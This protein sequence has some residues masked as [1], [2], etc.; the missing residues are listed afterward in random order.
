MA[1]TLCPI[2][3]GR[4]DEL[5]RLTRLVEEAVEGRGCLT[6]LMGEAGVGKSRLIRAVEA[7]AK[8][9]GMA[10]LVGR[11]VPGALSLPFRPLIE[12][13]LPTSRSLVG[14]DI[15]EL[16][17]FLGHLG[18][19]LPDLVE[20]G[21]RPEPT[22]APSELL[23]GEEVVR[24]LRL[25]GARTGC[26]LVLEDLHWADPETFAV[27]EYLAGV[28][29]DERILIVIS[30]RPERGSSVSTLV[31][32]LRG[33]EDGVL[34]L[35]PFPESLGRQVVAAC[36]ATTDP[37]PLLTPLVLSHSDGLP[38]LME[39]LLAGLVA[40]GSLTR[41]EDGSWNFNPP[42]RVPVPGSLADSVYLRLR[43]L[44]PASQRVI[45]AASLLGRRF[46]WQILPGIAGLDG[47][48]VVEALRQAVD[49]Q[50]LAVDRDSFRFRHALTRDAVLDQIL[51]P[52]RAELA[53]RTLTA[54]ERAHPGLPDPWCD[55]AAD[56]A[57]AQG[58]LPKA[59][60]LVTECA[61]RALLGGALASAEALAKRATE[62]APAHSGQ[63]DDAEEILVSALALAG[64]VSQALHRGKPLLDRLEV[65]A[66]LGRRVELALIL[67]RAALSGGD[68]I[69]AGA[70]IDRARRL[71]PDSD[72][73]MR[74]R[75][76]AVDAH[77]ELARGDAPKARQ[78][79]QTARGLAAREELAEVECEALEVLGRL[80]EDTGGRI[81][82]F[83]EAVDL[84]G[85]R[86]LTTWRLRALQE[87]ALTDVPHG[88]LDRLE[89]LRRVAAHTG[90]WVS[91]AQVDLVRADIELAG[92]DGPA[93]AEAASR[94]V[95]AS[96]RYGLDSLP[97]A[98]LWLAGSH[99]LAGR[100]AEMEEVLAQSA[101]LAPGDLRIQADSWGRVRAWFYASREDRP[102][103]RD[104]LERSM[105]FTRDAPRTRSMYVGQLYW[106]M[107]S[108]LCD[109]NLGSAA[110][111]EVSNSRIALTP[112]GTPAL[113]LIE[114]VALGRQGRG[115][116]AARLAGAADDLIGELG[117]AAGAHYLLRLV[118]EAAARDEWCRPTAPLLEAEAYFTGLGHHQMARQCRDLLRAAGATVPRRGR[119]SA[120]V[121]PGL[122]RLGITSRELDVLILIAQGHATRDIAASLVLSPRTVE[123]HVASL[124]ARIGTHTR[125]DLIAWARKNGYPGQLTR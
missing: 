46:D 77:V 75:V 18:R 33:S 121:P 58:D 85:R 10:V 35:H 24:L 11:A 61:R 29:C 23:V 7:D 53:G 12:A 1:S 50:M 30:A 28:V 84:A 82:Y 25:L 57:S 72:A 86:R 9:K 52:E 92:F 49:A 16:A 115:E 112:F 64:K 109:D 88:R 108:T 106:A 20:E 94:C 89:E 2:L 3:V 97:V 60:V 59:T 100:K 111:S 114:A 81:R 93:C 39:E 51:P 116:E 62:M 6:V 32:R 68:P 67:A 42:K 15:P 103:L 4:T 47:G 31:H 56:L 119:G 105:G 22:P 110:R 117:P 48:T 27:V 43:E 107:L 124:H 104:A 101:R 123:H 55:L 37:P 17:G 38:L 99:A 63:K 87:L 71:V 96:R 118:A 21:P 69:A 73:G 113:M 44:P 19:L 54:V 122:R 125:L 41:S 98:L 45:C 79:A 66:P 40:S 5:A 76:D 74:A 65:G 14:R 102:R 95:E 80:S 83:E 36:L 91:V 78:L 120:P 34:V 8:A 13:L 70:Q 26:L 90:A